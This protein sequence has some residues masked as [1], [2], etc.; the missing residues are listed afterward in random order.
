MYTPVG[1]L[2]TCFR[3][4][5]SWSFLGGKGQDTESNDQFGLRI[6][7]NVAGYSSVE[8]AGTTKLIEALMRGGYSSSL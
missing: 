3:G 8:A 4:I 2:N 6:A 5:N 1:K 7:S